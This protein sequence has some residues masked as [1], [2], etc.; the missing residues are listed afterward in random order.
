MGHELYRI[1]ANELLQT[2]VD[3]FE[4]PYDSENYEKAV[5]LLA[6]KLQFDLEDNIVSEW[7]CSDCDYQRRYNQ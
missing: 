7:F 5:E 1:W 3:H 2:L 4:D 6:V